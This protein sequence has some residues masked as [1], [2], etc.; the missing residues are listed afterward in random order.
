M[1]SL[2]VLTNHKWINLTNGESPWV[3]SLLCQH[4]PVSSSPVALLLQWVYGSVV[5]PIAGL[6]SL[7][8]A[9]LK[10]LAT[11]APAQN[12]ADPLTRNIIA[13]N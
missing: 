1:T 10:D 9:S 2:Q 5:S 4:S 13:L 11:E 3:I 12:L 7:S 8:L 6:Y